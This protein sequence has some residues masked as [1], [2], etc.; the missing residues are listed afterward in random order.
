MSNAPFDDDRNLNELRLILTP[1]VGPR[2]RKNLLEYFGSADEVFRADIYQ[3]CSVQ[4]VGPKIADAVLRAKNEINL[5]RELQFYREHGIRLLFESDPAYPPLLKGIFDPP[6]VLFVRGTLLPEDSV[7]LAVIGTRHASNYGERQT[8]RLVGEFVRAG[9]CIVSGLARGIDGFAHKAALDAGGRTVA[10]LGHGLALD[11]YPPENR[12]LAKRILDNNGAI[13]SEFPP[14][15]QASKGTF[16]QR[17]RIIAGMTLGTVVIE[18]GQRSGTSLTAQFAVDYGREVFAVPGPIDSRVS[19][20]CHQLIRDGARLLESVEDVLNELGPLSERIPTQDGLEIS[21][22]AEL[23]LTEPEKHILAAIPHDG[24]TVDQITQL[25]GI[26]VFK[27]M[28][29]ITSME[30][31][32]L[33]KR[34][35]GQRIYRA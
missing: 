27:I 15:T 12:G 4:D 26:P 11:I 19:A 9:F 1:G 33:L 30:M 31:K 14:L 3:L 25:T 17:N 24:A 6:G 32:R 21:R 29:L 7:S 22:P 34:G 13:I 20:G 16:P 10:V 5:E 2:T 8:F 28:T 35:T 18:A 23:G